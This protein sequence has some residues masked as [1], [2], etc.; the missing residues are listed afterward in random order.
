MKNTITDSEL[1]VWL[2]LWFPVLFLA[3]IIIVALYDFDLARNIVARENNLVELGTVVLLIPAVFAG[4]K[5][6]KLRKMFPDRRLGIWVFL[7]TIGCVYIGGEELSWGQ[8]LFKW[9]TPETIQAINDQNETNLHNISSWLDQKP[10]L[11]VE[12]SVLVGGIFLP[13]WRMFS[14]TGFTTNDWRY[15]FWPGFICL[16]TAVLAILVKVPERTK[17]FFDYILFEKSLRYSELQ[18]FYIALFLSIYLCS[19]YKRLCKVT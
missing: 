2:W 11:L 9:E 7:V 8:Q 13:L 5:S 3:F 19:I 18:E 4:Y 16:P 12:I 17:D 10:R 6:F 14:K 15:W 1:P